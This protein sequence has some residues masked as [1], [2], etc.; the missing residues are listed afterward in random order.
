MTTIKTIVLV[1][2]RF[3]ENMLFHIDLI[4]LLRLIEYF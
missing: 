3:C 2:P 1:E 4:K